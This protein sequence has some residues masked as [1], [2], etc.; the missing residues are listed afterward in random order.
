MGL[1]NLEEEIEKKRKVA[2]DLEESIKKTKILMKSKEKVLDTISLV[3]DNFENLKKFETYFEQINL[4]HKR[5]QKL[6]EVSAQT[7]GSLQKVQNKREK[8][9]KNLD[10]LQNEL[11]SL[12]VAPNFT[13][14]ASNSEEYEKRAKKLKTI[15]SENN[16]KLKIFHS[17]IKKLTED[18]ATTKSEEQSLQS[19]YENLTKSANFNFSIVNNLQ[20][21]GFNSTKSLK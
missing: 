13:S 10:G 20:E 8:L 6:T 4:Y 19:N 15:T 18:L 1:R 5:I 3:G 7:T 2:V 12:G 14:L 17:K 16:S 9:E 21:K 11:E